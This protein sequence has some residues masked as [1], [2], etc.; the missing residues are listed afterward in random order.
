MNEK[1]TKEAQEK[2]DWVIKKLEL[3]IK[4]KVMNYKDYYPTQFFSRGN[5]LIKGIN[6]REEWIEDT[7]P[8][9][10]YIPGELNSLLRDIEQ[11]AKRENKSKRLTLSRSR[12][13]RGVS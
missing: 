9:K 12:R 3:N 6:I 10:N 8:I 2:L 7:N 5:I 1:R 13:K 4:C 11:K